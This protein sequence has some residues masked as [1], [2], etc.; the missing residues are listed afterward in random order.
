MEV[1]CEMCGGNIAVPEDVIQ[2]EILACPDCGL[3]FEIQ[4]LTSGHISLRPAEAIKEDWG[5]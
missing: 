2:G 4:S 5:E 3:D 1:E